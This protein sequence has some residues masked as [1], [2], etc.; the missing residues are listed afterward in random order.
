M[1]GKGKGK[2]ITCSINTETLEN[3][4]K[5]LENL[6]N[7]TEVAEPSSPEKLSD[8]NPKDLNS[9]LNALLEAVNVISHQISDIKK[10]VHGSDEKRLCDELTFH[11]AEID[12][13]KQRSLKGNLILSNGSHQEVSLIKSDKE[14]GKNK[15]ALLKHVTDL[16]CQKYK[17]IV[18]A[19]DVQACHRLPNGKVIL[20]IWNRKPG[21]AWEGLISAIKTGGDRKL[22]FY[23]NFQLTSQ[24]SSLLFQLRNLYREKKISKVFTDENGHISF[25]VNSES[26][27]VRVTY[28]KTDGQDNNRKN[29]EFSEICRQI[30]HA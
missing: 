23:A 30:N 20:R 29:L 28:V 18:P 25:K 26:S 2:K 5:G 8:T 4:T 1:S 14:L 17:V 27:K 10:K 16:L 11:K 3:L 15:D 24:R 6:R 22:D 9:V 19:E 21:S 7:Q 12:E 13:I